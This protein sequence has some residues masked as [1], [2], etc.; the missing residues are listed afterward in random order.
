MR[1]DVSNADKDK[2]MPTPSHPTTKPAS[3]TPGPWRQTDHHVM[4]ANGDASDLGDRIATCTDPRQR[5]AE[6][7]ARLIAATP[8][9]LAA[10][11]IAE[12]GLRECLE[13]IDS[14]VDPV[15]WSEAKARLD[16]VRS[17]IRLAEGRAS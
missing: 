2:T 6:A 10:L 15:Y 3:H 4:R 11:R 8:T 1:S 14:D 13:L 9:M 16:S 12:T 17:A 7:N 5:V